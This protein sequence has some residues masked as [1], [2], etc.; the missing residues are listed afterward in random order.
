MA[1]RNRRD[2]I[3]AWLKQER[4]EGRSGNVWYDGDTIYS[5]GR[6]FPMARLVRLESG[7]TVALFT[8]RTYSITTSH[9]LGLVKGAL[10]VEGVRTFEVA[11][12]LLHDSLRATDVAGMLARAS[13]MD[14][15]AKRARVNGDYYR[16]QAMRLR[17]MAADYALAF[18]SGDSTLLRMVRDAMPPEPVPYVEVDRETAYGRTVRHTP[19]RVF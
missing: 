6:H 4:P 19:V 3:A 16:A 7:E 1:I 5:Y 12:V 14:L 15:K 10:R 2:V 9:H 8:T 18:D 11:D 13:E 17:T